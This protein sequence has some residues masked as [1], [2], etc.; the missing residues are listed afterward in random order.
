V[1]E[2]LLI[3]LPNFRVGSGGASFLELFALNDG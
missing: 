2:A 1:A 3:E